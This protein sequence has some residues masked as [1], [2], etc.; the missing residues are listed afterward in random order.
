[1]KAFW[2]SFALAGIEIKTH[3]PVLALVKEPKRTVAESEMCR[4]EHVGMPT[5]S[6][7]KRS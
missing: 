4:S 7:L 2:I 6:L 5:V 3:I 1:M